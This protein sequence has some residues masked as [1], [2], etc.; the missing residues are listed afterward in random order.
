MLTGRSTQQPKSNINGLTGLMS[1]INPFNVPT[2]WSPGQ[3]GSDINSDQPA[4]LWEKVTAAAL[5]SHPLHT[6]EAQV[7]ITSSFG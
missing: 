2:G 1:D 3:P 6:S 7:Y 4:Q 5:G